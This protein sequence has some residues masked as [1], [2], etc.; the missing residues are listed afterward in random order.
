MPAK[1]IAG[2]LCLQSLF[3]ACSRQPAGTLAYVSNERDG[4]ITVI[5]TKTDKVV[6][7]IQ[8]GAVRARGLRLSPD[9]KIL[10]VAL[11]TPSGKLYED[12]DNRIA[13]ID[14]AS[15]RVTSKY[16]VG[17]DPEQLAVGNGGKL[18][19]ASN[20]D[21]GTA[22]VTDVETRRTIATLVVGIEPEGVS[23]SPDG[24]WV[25]VTAETSNTVS[26]IDTQKNEV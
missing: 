20:E 13:A 19:Y 9:G 26:V 16:E 24:R 7:T 8:L 22:T 15:G 10:Y 12:A 4:T 11:S 14:T 6:S 17:R 5:D 18:L 2:L 25:Y 23:I 21:A 3:M 1:L